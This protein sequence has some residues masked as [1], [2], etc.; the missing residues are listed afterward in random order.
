[1]KHY[2]LKDKKVIEAES[3]W[4]WAMWV[5]T[6]D[7]KVKHTVL[8]GGITVSTVFLFSD[9]RIGEG[10]PLLFETTMIFG[11][12]HAPYKQYYSTYDEAIAGHEKVVLDLQAPII[13]AKGEL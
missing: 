11:E 3:A 13:I 5:R 8:P 2:I 1:M 10:E 9:H 7:T 4:D 12:G 6:G